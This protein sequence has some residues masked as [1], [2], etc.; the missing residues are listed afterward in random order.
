MKL[1][2]LAEYCCVPAKGRDL[3]EVQ[4]PSRT[5]ERLAFRRSVPKPCLHPFHD[6]ATQDDE[7]LNSANAPKCLDSNLPPSWLFQHGISSAAPTIAAHVLRYGV[8][9]CWHGFDERDSGFRWG[10]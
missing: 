10:G 6:Q 4:N 1:P 8:A 5:P 3:L 2:S 7:I 9:Q